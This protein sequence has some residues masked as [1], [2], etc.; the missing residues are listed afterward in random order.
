MHY[1]IISESENIINFILTENNITEV[2]KGD[3]ERHPIMIDLEE[4][5]ISSE[6]DS[7]TLGI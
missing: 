4:N 3:D 6:S 7:K 2:I 1:L 5:D